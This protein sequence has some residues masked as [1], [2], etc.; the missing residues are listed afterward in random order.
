M[1]ISV[2]QNPRPSIY[3]KTRFVNLDFGY[4]LFSLGL[5]TVLL[6]FSFFFRDLVLYPVRYHYSFRKR[7]VLLI[8]GQR[9]TRSPRGGERMEEE[10]CVFH[11][12]PNFFLLEEFWKM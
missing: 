9:L 2:Q 3:K 1:D 4:F 12:G 7:L 6:F 11:T 8:H 5:V 10:M